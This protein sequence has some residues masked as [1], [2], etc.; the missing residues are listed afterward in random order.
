[1]ILNPMTRLGRLHQNVLRP[2]VG[3]S[4]LLVFLKCGVQGRMSPN[5]QTIDHLRRREIAH[6]N[7]PGTIICSERDRIEFGGEAVDA[8]LRT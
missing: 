1:M 7:P 2:Y 4:F 6:V 8:S 5:A 3:H